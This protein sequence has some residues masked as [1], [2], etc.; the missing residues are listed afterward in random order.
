MVNQ[1]YQ[2]IFEEKQEFGYLPN[3]NK[4]INQ[5]Y[6]YICNISLYQLYQPINNISKPK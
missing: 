6:H 4:L 3:T 5:L 1:K 2:Y